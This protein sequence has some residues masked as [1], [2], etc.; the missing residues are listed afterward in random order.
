MTD[1]EKITVRFSKEDYLIWKIWE[2]Y[3]EK[4]TRPAKIES[5][6][7]IRSGIRVAVEN[8]IFKKRIVDF[9]QGLNNEKLKTKIQNHNFYDPEVLE[10]LQ[11]RL[12]EWS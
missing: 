11:K 1:Q 6:E 8:E 9:L 12:K 10:Y 4:R 2:Q 5:P 7:M 3:M